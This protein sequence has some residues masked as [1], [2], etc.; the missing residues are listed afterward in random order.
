MTNE[1]TRLHAAVIGATSGVGE[2][3]VNR[4]AIKANVSVFGRRITKLKEMKLG[5]N[6]LFIHAMDVKSLDNIEEGLRQC[7]SLFG[8]LDILIYCAGE[9][10]L[11]PQRNIESEEI[12][13]M[14]KVNL[15]GAMYIGKL[16]AS[17]Y[18]SEKNAVMCAISSVAGLR[19]E[20]A[21]VGYSVFKAGLNALIKGLARECGPRRFVGVA[22][23]WLDTE[24]TRAQSFYT[25]SF[26]EQLKRCS[27]L[28]LTNID[29]VVDTIEFLTSTNASSITGQ[30]LCVDAG[31][32]L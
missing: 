15:R 8:K 31:Y 10:I 1:K 7:V 30:I 21:L 6:D 9:Q 25:D 18:F 16:F 32:S 27:P 19:P 24:M 12:D 13:S 17:N 29:S 26:I 22:P 20:A 4:L 3:V 2:L 14:Y 28:G 5:C 11:K 23:G